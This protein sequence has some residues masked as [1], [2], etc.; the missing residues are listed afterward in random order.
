MFGKQ[1]QFVDELHTNLIITHAFEIHQG[2]CNTIS[3]DGIRHNENFF[4]KGLR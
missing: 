4:L 1:K 2:H 3:P